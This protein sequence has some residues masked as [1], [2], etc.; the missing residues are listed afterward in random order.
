MIAFSP[1]CAA[2][3]PPRVDHGD[4]PHVGMRVGLEQAGQRLGRRSARAHQLEARAG[5]TTDRRTTGS[6]PRRRPPRR[7]ATIAP[8]RRT[9]GTGPRRRARRSRGR[10]PRSSTSR[11]AAAAPRRLASAA[12]TRSEGS[13]AAAITRARAGLTS[14]LL[15]PLRARSDTSPSPDPPFRRRCPAARRPFATALTSAPRSTRSSATA[16]RPPRSPRGAGCSRSRSSI[17][18]PCPRPRSISMAAVSR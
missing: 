18:R 1:V 7:T 6:R 10:A 8:D 9:S 16:P 2:T 3:L 11:P 5:R 17:A 14:P 12:R 4:L 13:A 15:A